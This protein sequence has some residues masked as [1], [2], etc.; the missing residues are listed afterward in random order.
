MR[1]LPLASLLTLSIL[2][3][4]CSADSGTDDSIFAVDTDGSG[5]VDCADLDHVLACLHHPESDVCTEVDVNHDGLVDDADVHDIHD[6]LAATGHHCGEP[7]HHDSEGHHDAEHDG[8]HDGDHDSDGHPD[9][10]HGD[11]TGDHTDDGHHDDG[12]HDDAPHS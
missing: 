5:E 10:D 11:H 1:Q 7:D 2:L 6:G 9:T 4:A 3:P 12:L 8:D